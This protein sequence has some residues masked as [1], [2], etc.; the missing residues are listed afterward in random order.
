MSISKESIKSVIIS[1]REQVFETR[2]IVRDLQSEVEGAIKTPFIQIVSGIRRSG[3]STIIKQIRQKQKIRNYSINFDDNRLYNFE[4]EDFEKLNDA[5]LELFGEENIYY[6]DE[7]Q[8]IKGWERYVRRLYNEGK[9]IFVT[10]S[11]A[12]MLSKEMGTHLTGRN[13][14]SEL[15][16]F[17]FKEFLRWEKIEFGKNDIYNPVKTAKLRQLFSEYLKTGGFPEFIKTG[18]QIFL[19]SLYDDILYRDVIARYKVQHEKALVELLHY[20]VS[21]SSKEFSYNTLKNILGLSNAMTVKE[22][23]G[24]FEQSYLLFTINKFDYSLK[25]QLVNPKKI[26][27]IDTGLANS[28]SFQFSENF[29]RQLENIVFLQLK[30]YGYEVFYHKGKFECD[31]LIREKSAI[32]NAI[33]VSKSLTDE[34]TRKREIRG[35]I[36]AMKTYGLKKGLILTFEETE[37]IAVDELIIEVLPVWQWLLQ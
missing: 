31:F 19:K 3:K 14:R 7:I 18:N 10:G 33:Q 32:V 35:I 27:V 13:I 29:G 37:T 30:R 1:Q 22:Y 8:N 34:N 5:F 11:N 4:A 9:K 15:Y 17:S 23:I 26:Y 28:I 16:P 21:N 12:L 24:Y 2:L 6:F 20:L 25:K 36:E